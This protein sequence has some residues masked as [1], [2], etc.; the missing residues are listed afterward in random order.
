MSRSHKPKL[1]QNFLS[2]LNAR[3]RIVDALGDVSEAMVIEIGPGHG[4]ITELLA[5]RAKRLF[6]IEL[7]RALVP[8]LRF[9]FRNHANV[10]IIEADI[11]TVDL[12][13]LIASKFPALSSES[14]GSA[15]SPEL[16]AT[17]TE[18]AL[19]P[20]RVGSCP[21][22]FHVIGNL[23]YYITSDILLHLFRASLAAPGV[24]ASAIVMM[25]R[26]VAERVASS[27][28]RREFGLLSATAQMHATAEILFTLGP[29]SFSPPP[30]VDSS[31][32]RLR[33]RPRFAEL[34][35]ERA[36]FDRFLHQA[37]AQKRKTLAKN[38]RQAGFTPEE[39]ARA[40]PATL[41]TQVR[42]EASSLEDLAALH[43]GIEVARNQSNST[44]V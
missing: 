14:A 37:F 2:D 10:E 21:A 31:V 12:P 40:W 32:L 15:R 36:A 42:A 29:E 19:Q 38:L 8:E 22:P 16:T 33:F 34:G 43:H 5:M 30:A 11:L 9:R 17:G 27:P 18:E 1:G 7:D 39:L 23:P 3:Q 26:E 20:E 28:G 35:V 44:G 13:A 4:A 24:M 6:A 25:Q 41:E